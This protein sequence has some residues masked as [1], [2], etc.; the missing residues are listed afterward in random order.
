MARVSGQ[1]PRLPGR[2]KRVQGWS[3]DVPK[4]VP[5]PEAGEDAPTGR[6]QGQVLLS[7]AESHPHLLFGT[8]GAAEAL[9]SW[10]SGCELALLAERPCA[11]SSAMSSLLMSVMNI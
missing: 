6:E 5:P 3:C 2:A 7:E 9:V 4:D 1:S 8:L 11:G 10:L